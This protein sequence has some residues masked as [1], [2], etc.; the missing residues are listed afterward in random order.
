VTWLL[1]VLFDAPELAPH[2]V[3]KGGTSLS[4]VYRLIQ[5]FSEDIDLSV[6]PSFLGFHAADLDNL[7]SRTKRAA[8]ME[9]MQEECRKVTRANVAPTLEKQIARYLGKSPNGQWLAYDE[10]PH[11]QCPI[12]YFEYPGVARTGLPYIQRRVKLEL[13]SLTEQ[14]PTSQHPIRPWIA[15]VLPQVFDDWKCNVTALDISR[16]FWEKAT[17]LHSEFHRPADQPTPDRYA[18]HYYDV[19]QLLQHKDAPVFTMNKALAIQVANWKAK[20]FARNSAKYDTAHH[21][22]LRL[23]PSEARRAQLEE[24]YADMKPFFLQEP[25]SFQAVID[26]LAAAEKAINAPPKA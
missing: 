9:A 4:K 13:G 17:I 25:P 23:L 20:F 7:Q 2:I 5:R 6:S 16:T 24:D 8:A 11:T 14:Q 18:R 21:G 12:I 1:G 26:Q 22:S 10:D 19:A 3:F 15:D